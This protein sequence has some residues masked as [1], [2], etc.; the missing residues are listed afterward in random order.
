MTEQEFET[1][2]IGTKETEKLTPAKVKIVK[3]TIEVVGEKGSKKVQCEVQHPSSQT[4]IKISAAKIERKGKLDV[5]GLWFNQDEDKLI[6]K[7]SL[8]A[9]FLNFMNVPNTK[10]LEGKECLTVEDDSGYLVFKA[11]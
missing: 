7:G 5:G 6:K 8:L 1:I 11:Y 4:T 3:T 2:G 10:E 9:S